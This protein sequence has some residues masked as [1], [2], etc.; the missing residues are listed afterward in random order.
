VP[1]EIMVP[2]ITTLLRDCKD[3]DLLDLIYRLLIQNAEQLHD[4]LELD[5]VQVSQG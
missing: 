5:R 3:I 1:P 2:R 4:S